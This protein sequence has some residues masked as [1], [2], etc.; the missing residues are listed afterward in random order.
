MKRRNENCA[1]RSGFTLIELLVVIAIIAILAA[2]LLPALSAAKQRALVTQCLNN[3][4]QLGLA[5][6]VY[7]DENRDCYPWGI[8]VKNDLTWTNSTA[9]HIVLLPFLSGNVLSGSKCYVC[10]SDSDGAKATFPVPP[11]YIKWQQDYR[12]NAYMFRMTNAAPKAPLHTSTVHAPSSM[13]MITEKEYDSPDFQTTSDELQAWLTGWNTGSGKNYKNSGFERHN[14][15]VP[16]VTAADGHATRFKV[17][18]YTGG[19]GAANPNYFPGLGDTRVDA[20]PSSTW[21]T[22][23]ADLYMRD[24]NSAAG[25]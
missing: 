17:P 8:D 20:A 3:A 18:P 16:V 1:A 22:P 2:M 23:G 4:K 10:P 5:T 25:F 19:G 14:K 6:M 11:G 15:V 24:F 9:W 12:A 7:V 13:L 21:N